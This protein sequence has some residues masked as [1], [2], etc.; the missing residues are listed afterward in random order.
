MVYRLFSAIDVGSD[1]LEMKIYEISKDKGIRIIDDIRHTMELGKDTYVTGSVN[2][3]HM[4][5]LENV[6][7]DFTKIMKEY[8][9]NDYVAYTTSSIREAKNRH[10]ILDR[11]RVKTGLNVCV[12]SNSEQRFLSYKAMSFKPDFFS[13]IEEGTLIID[14]GAGSIQVSLYENGFLSTTQNIKLG[15]LRIRELI[16]GLSTDKEHFNSLIEELINN[17]LYT[18][19][20]MFIKDKKIKNIIAIGDYGEYFV[21][22]EMN[23][24]RVIGKDEFFSRYKKLMKKSPEELSKS[25]DISLEQALRFIPAMEVYNR[26][27]EETKAEKIWFPMVDLCDG[28]AFDYAIKN[29]KIKL[30]HDFDEDILNHS[31]L[32]A[33]RYKGNQEHIA[34]LE[35]NVVKIFD[36]MKKYHGLGKN[37][38]KLLQIAAILHDCGKYISINSAGESSYNIIMATEIIGLSHREREIVANVVKYNT[39]DI[40]EEMDAYKGRINDFMLVVKMVAILKVANAMDRSHKQKFRDF[41]VNLKENKLYITSYNSTDITLEK[42]L[43]NAKAKFFEDVYGIKPVLRQ[44]K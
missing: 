15:S 16:Y 24:E 25:F 29:K 21:K 41:K 7:L 13:F 38:R 10:I 27:L 34:I 8:N 6:L 19:K 39:M 22:D 1:E 18:F 42:G 26:F 11:I 35:K 33:K 23:G 30:L 2:L 37:E 28:I 4:D 44:K 31:R 20:K 36:V 32:I 17:D 40:F 14:V 9:V 5:E 43:F 12:L 3:S